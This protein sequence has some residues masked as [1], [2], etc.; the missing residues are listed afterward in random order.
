MSSLNLSGRTAIGCNIY[1]FSDSTLE[2]NKIEVFE[3][4]YRCNIHD[5]M[6]S[7]IQLYKPREAEASEIQYRLVQ[8]FSMET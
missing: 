2:L 5:F 8:D 4:P 7:V 3:I 6:I 1:D